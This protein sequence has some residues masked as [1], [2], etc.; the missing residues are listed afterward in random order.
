MLNVLAP[1]HP[2]ARALLDVFR[3]ALGELGYIEGRTMPSRGSAEP[4]VP[5]LLHVS[6]ELREQS[7]RRRGIVQIDHLV[8]RV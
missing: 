1:E 5:V 4:E 6:D 8:G 7:H 3:Q 2:E